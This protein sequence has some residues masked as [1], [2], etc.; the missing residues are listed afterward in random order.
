[1][2]SKKDEKYEEFTYEYRQIIV[3]QTLNT[4]LAI[5]LLSLE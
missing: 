1:M 3:I 5:Y 2:D 4:V